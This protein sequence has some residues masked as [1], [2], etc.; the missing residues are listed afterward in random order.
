MLFMLSV[1]FAYDFIDLFQYIIGIKE[2]VVDGYRRSKL[3][4]DGKAK[5]ALIV[6]SMIFIA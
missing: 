2:E 4:C 3:M 5:P 1:K 6:I